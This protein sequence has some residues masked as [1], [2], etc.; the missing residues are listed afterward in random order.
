MKNKLLIIFF[1]WFCGI[2]GALQAQTIN[3]PSEIITALNKGDGKILATY[4]DRDVEILLPSGNIGTAQ[5]QAVARLNKFFGENPV[6]TFAIIHQGCKNET[7]F[8]IGTLKTTSNEYR[9]NLLMRMVNSDT[10]IQQ[11]RIEKL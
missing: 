10:K 2:S 1:L 9:V 11:I 7:S 6:K 3:I 5:G 4:F 8:L